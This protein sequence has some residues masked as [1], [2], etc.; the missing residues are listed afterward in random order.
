MALIQGLAS[1]LSRRDGKFYL[2]HI[3]NWKTIIIYNILFVLDFVTNID[4]VEKL[5]FLFRT[6][7][8]IGFKVMSDF[9]LLSVSNMILIV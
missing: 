7:N 5:T 3:N 2:T 6:E 4:G 1:S 8:E 9:S